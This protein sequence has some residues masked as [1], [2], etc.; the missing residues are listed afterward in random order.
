VY[1]LKV[2][3]GQTGHYMLVKC[4]C[5]AEIKHKVPDWRVDC[6]VCNQSVP[7]GDVAPTP[8]KEP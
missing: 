5:G 6:P 4:D 1:I 8:P 3:A 7:I 2:V